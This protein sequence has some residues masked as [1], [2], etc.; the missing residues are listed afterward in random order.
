MRS[1]RLTPEEEQKRDQMILQIFAEQDPLGPTLEE[2]KRE[3][4]ESDYPDGH[5][6]RAYRERIWIYNYCQYQVG[7]SNEQLKP[8][9]LNSDTANLE[10]VSVL[11]HKACGRK[12]VDVVRIPMFRPPLIWQADRL[13]LRYRVDGGS[14]SDALVGLEPEKEIV[15][16]CSD[17]V[18]NTLSLSY[19]ALLSESK[20]H[21]IPTE[22]PTI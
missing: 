20:V 9:R 21:R 15:L 4:M 3:E 1:R 14:L 17:C 6:E 16:F 5:P 7:W 10:Q 19:E 13:A 22:S 12:L 18:A 11:I 2:L 8:S